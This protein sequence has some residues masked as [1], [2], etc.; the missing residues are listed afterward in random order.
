LEVGSIG[1]AIPSVAFA[2]GGGQVVDSTEDGG[3]TW[4]ASRFDETLAAA[5]YGSTVWAVVEGDRAGAPIWLYESNSGGRRWVYTA[6]LP[7]TGSAVEL[8]RPDARTA[9]VLLASS[10]GSL[11]DAYIM[12]STDGGVKWSVRSN[13][14]GPL[15]K[16][17]VFT[18]AQ[19]LAASHDELWLACGGP[20][21][22]NRGL[23][24]QERKEVFSSEDGGRTWTAV[25]ATL[26]RG[27]T[28]R[29]GRL[30]LSGAVGPTGVSHQVAFGNQGYWIVLNQGIASGPPRV[31]DQPLLVR[32][33]DN[34]KKWQEVGE[35]LTRAHPIRVTTAG[36]GTVVQTTEGLWELAP[37]GKWSHL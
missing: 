23:G 5:G 19:L 32:A 6:R 31:V 30:P 29:L 18:Q 4:W 11:G 16:S 17:V 33:S 9:Y 15:G 7:G 22:F 14:C 37:S 25:A 2:Y 34:G 10:A 12:A 36:S 20:V 3:S 35:P 8:L 1:A 26:T 24:F 28:N 13:P 27:G 21:T